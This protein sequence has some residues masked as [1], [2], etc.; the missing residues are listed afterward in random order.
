MRW[1]GGYL[2]WKRAYWGHVYSISQNIIKIHHWN[3]LEIKDI[4]MNT[5]RHWKE[6][7]TGRSDLL[8][9][10]CPGITLWKYHVSAIKYIII[11]NVN[12]NYGSLP[13]ILQIN[14]QM[15]MPARIFTSTK[16]TRSKKKRRNIYCKITYYCYFLILFPRGRSRPP[17]MLRSLLNRLITHRS[18]L[19]W[20]NTEYHNL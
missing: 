16:S 12:L 6:I 17:S 18:G 8:T 4:A 14:L 2:I 13:V 9:R 3:I 5:W 11:M 1:P 7:G 10:G 19:N 20:R 15:L